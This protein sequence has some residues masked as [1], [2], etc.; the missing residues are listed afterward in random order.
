MK[1]IP[2]EWNLASVQLLEERH[3]SESDNSLGDWEII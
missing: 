1:V 2:R 3:K